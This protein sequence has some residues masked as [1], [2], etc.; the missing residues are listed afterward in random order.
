MCNNDKYLAAINLQSASSIVHLIVGGMKYTFEH[1]FLVH[2]NWPLLSRDRS[3]WLVNL[4]TY[5]SAS[6]IGTYMPIFVQTGS[7]VAH[8]TYIGA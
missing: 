3:V 2:K 5:Y 8:V 4:H 1:L 7:G 6:T